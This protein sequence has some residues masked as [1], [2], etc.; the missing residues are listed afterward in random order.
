MDIKINVPEVVALFKE[1]QESRERFFEMIRFNVQ[2]EVGNYLSKLM[3]MELTPFL[4]RKPYERKGTDPNYRNGGYDRD[5]TL[6][7]IGEVQ[8]RVPRDRDSKFETEVL[9]RSKQ[10]EESISR[11]ISLM[12]LMGISTR[13]LSLLSG[14][15]LGRSIS[16]EEVSQ[17]SRDLV[18]GVERWR[19]RDLSK[20]SI[21]YLFIDGVN[22]SMRMSGKVEKVPVLVVIGTTEAGIKMV[23][24][25]QRGDKESAVCWREL[26][27]DL[28]RR[29]SV[30]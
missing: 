14:S 6:K 23:I 19:Q 25:L 7:G 22:F 20:E 16:H 4:G 1:I 17:A 10:Y 13:S 11:D 9:P 12:F 15:L 30:A 8:V 24:G 26:F 28:K 5:F 2:E 27:G 18:E 29:G 21:K 3:D